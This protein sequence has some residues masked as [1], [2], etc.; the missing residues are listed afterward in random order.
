MKSSA[1]IMVMMMFHYCHDFFVDHWPH[2]SGTDM[3][4]NH[5]MFVFCWSKLAGLVLN[6]MVDSDLADIVQ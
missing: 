3:S 2:N 1:I 5:N 4:M 6:K